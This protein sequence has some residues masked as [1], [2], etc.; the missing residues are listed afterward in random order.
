MRNAIHALQE[1]ATTS[2]HV[3]STRFPYPAPAHSNPNLPHPMVNNLLPRSSSH[4]PEIFLREGERS[5]KFVDAQTQTDIPLGLIKEFVIENSIT[6]LEWLNLDPSIMYKNNQIKK[7]DIFSG[8]NINS[9][10]S[11]TFNDDN[12]QN[13]SFSNHNMSNEHQPDWLTMPLTPPSCW[14]NQHH[15]FSAGDLNERATQQIS[16]A[17]NNVPSSRSLKFHPCS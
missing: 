15:R 17:M 11:V 13:I 2:S 9:S 6:V 10:N 4:P 14:N 7:C 5:L 12:Q 16:S 3:A 8:L 1:L